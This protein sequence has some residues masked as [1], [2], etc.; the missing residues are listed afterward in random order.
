MSLTNHTSGDRFMPCSRPAHS[1]LLLAP[2]KQRWMR[3]GTHRH[4][5]LQQA[6]DTRACMRTF[7]QNRKTH[8]SCVL[9]LL[10]L[11]VGSEYRTE[12]VSV[13]QHDSSCASAQAWNEDKLCYDTRWQAPSGIHQNERPSHMMLHGPFSQLARVGERAREHQRPTTNQP[14][15]FSHMSWHRGCGLVGRKRLAGAKLTSAS[16]SRV[17]RKR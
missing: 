15:D 7:V 10:Q 16:L 12:V 5:V 13:Q 11:V 2:V 9:L 8:L 3:L 6:T 4:R 14:N 17:A 1:Y